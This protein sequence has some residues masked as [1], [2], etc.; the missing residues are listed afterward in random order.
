MS[1]IK[2][3]LDKAEKEKSAKMPVNNDATD[4][5]FL[6]EN[7]VKLPR[8]KRKKSTTEHYV[9]KYKKTLIFT[10]VFGLVCIIILFNSWNVIRKKTRTKSDFAYNQKMNSNQFLF[11]DSTARELYLNNTINKEALETKSDSQLNELQKFDADNKKSAETT[12]AKPA[13]PEKISMLSKSEPQKKIWLQNSIETTNIQSLNEIDKPAKIVNTKDGIEK[14]ETKKIA[15]KPNSLKSEI[16][17]KKNTSDLSNK[18]SD[19]QNEKNKID[20][21]EERVKTVRD[22]IKTKTSSKIKNTDIKNDSIKY[23]TELIKNDEKQKALKLLENIIKK[24][25]DNIEANALIAELYYNL[26]NYEKAI[27]Y[28][29]KLASLTKNN[30]YNFKIGICYRTFLEDNDAAKYYLKIYLRGKGKNSDNARE[31]LQSIQ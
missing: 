15:F 2:K 19:T 9:F 3:A 5:A 23:I 21:S 24:N 20:F 31:L 29:K 26:E 1:I 11:N 8:P 25:P 7:I 18:N 27:Q 4:D 28:Y 16:S 17:N 12:A 30:E 6:Y 22:E 14:S 13:E 10:F